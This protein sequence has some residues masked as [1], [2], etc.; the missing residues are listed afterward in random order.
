[1]YS[2]VNRTDALALCLVLF[3]GILLTATLGRWC[4]KR[5]R[6]D[7]HELKGGVN[8][9]LSALFA[10]SGLTLAFTFGM[11]GNRMENVRGVVRQE[12]N[13]I[14]SAIRRAEFYPDS[15]REKFRADF[16]EY[17]EAVIHFYENA[18]NRTQLYKAIEDANK[19]G[20]RLWTRVAQQSKQPNM[21][22]PSN[23]MTPA[24]DKMLDSATTR[25]T[26]LKSK[27]P[28][29]VIYM[30][31]IC[32]LATCFI[33]GFTSSAFHYKDW[34]IITGFAIITSMVVY[35][36]L[37]LARPMRGIIKETAGKEAIVELRKMF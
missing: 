4:N 11:S 25:I 24:L 17:V 21:L 2:L 9:L 1:M 27:V 30:L 22:I 28:D 16:K 6:G 10:L 13:D 32:V 5:W 3:C 29:L 37:D 20:E 19:I 14:S 18:T 33:G 26:V 8:S 7:A 31:F 15:V 35:T 36:T 12:A 23:Q 34:I